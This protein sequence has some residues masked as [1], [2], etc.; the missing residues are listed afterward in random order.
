M[1][2][3]YFDAGVHLEGLRA[4]VI[5]LQDFERAFDDRMP[6]GVDIVDEYTRY[7][8]ERCRRCDG[9]VLVALS[10][11]DVAGFATVLTKVRSQSP[12]DGQFEYGLVSDLVVAERFRGQ[13]IGRML[14]IEAERHARACDVKWLRIGVLADNIAADGLYESMGFRRLYVE[15]EKTLQ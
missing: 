11:D 6:V 12:D 7:M 5:E 4:C 14:L 8:L 13:G 10:G 15:R 2:I 9:Q 3:R 1:I